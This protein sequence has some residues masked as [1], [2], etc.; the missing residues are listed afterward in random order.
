MN[1]LLAYIS[2]VIAFLLIYFSLI[3]KEINFHIVT[4]LFLALLGISILFFWN[5]IKG[6]GMKD[7]RNNVWFL[8]KAFLL[9]YGTYNLLLI[10]GGNDEHTTF[11]WIVKIIIALIFISF[12]IVIWV[13]N[14]HRQPRK[15]N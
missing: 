7:T 10:G 4:I 8:I 9:Y 14:I 1:R 15:E 3:V 12:P 13:K 5:V 11:L 6:Y 2:F